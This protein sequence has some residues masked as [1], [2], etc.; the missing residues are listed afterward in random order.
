MSYGKL[1][2]ALGQYHLDGL[3]MML[4]QYLPIKLA[5]HPLPTSERRLRRFETIIGAAVCDYIGTFGLDRYVN[6]YVYVTAKCMYIT[7]G[8]CFN[9]PGW[10]TDGFGTEDINYIWYDAHPT[11]F[12]TGPFTDISDDHELSIQQFDA[13]AKEV[14]AYAPEMLLR[15]DRYMVHRVN[16]EMPGGMRTFLK[17]SIS[18]DKYNLKGN[19]VNYDLPYSWDMADRKEHRNT[20]S[21]H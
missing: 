9:R 16:P 3:E 8:S 20:P 21:S 6:A 15:L 7:P 18:A 5:G 11:Q 13:Q 19:S 17:V 1:P 14:V 4:Y 12:S 2:T 10:H